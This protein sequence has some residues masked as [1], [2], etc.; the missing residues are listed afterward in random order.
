M[1]FNSVKH[2][3]TPDLTGHRFGRLTVV[4]FAGV[5][6]NGPRKRQSQWNCKCTCGQKTVVTTAK[7]NYGWTTSCGCWQREAP[8]HSKKNFK[9]GQSNT[10][11][12]YAYHSMKQRCLNPNFHHYKNWGGR[13]ITIC[14]RWIDSFEAFLTDMG[15]RPSN[16]HS[17]DRKKNNGNYNKDNCHWITAK[18]Q[19]ANRRRPPKRRPA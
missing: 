13:G 15:L 17:L 16:K 19:A 10:P 3:H 11:E 14:K 9:H 4:D 8:A 1:L 6:D 18:K 12:Y 2:P 5:K 7:L